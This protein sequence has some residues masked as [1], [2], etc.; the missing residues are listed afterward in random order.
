MPISDDGFQYIINGDYVAIG[1]GS[2]SYGNGIVDKN[3]QFLNVPSSI[4][5]KVVKEVLY[6]AFGFLSQLTSA[7][8]P[9]SIEIIESDIF[10]ECRNLRNV[11]FQEP[12][13]V[14]TINIWG[15]YSCTSLELIVFPRSLSYIGSNTF[16][17]CSSLKHVFVPNS[18]C[19]F[20]TSFNNAGNSD[21]IIHVSKCFEGSVNNAILSKNIECFPEYSP[22]SKSNHQIILLLFFST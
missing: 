5:G 8:L 19:E 10:I 21:L 20:D 22:F 16:S 6:R 15:F 17:G 1:D 4:D 12:S 7:I 3:I 2:V 11:Y 9:A 18:H 14:K 13:R